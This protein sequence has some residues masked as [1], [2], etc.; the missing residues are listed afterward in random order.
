M[1]WVRCP[2]G[3]TE[4]LV[5]ARVSLDLGSPVFEQLVAARL[6]AR[7]EELW[8]GHRRQLREQRDALVAAM[9]ERLPDWRFRVPAGGLSL[10][11][12]LPAGPRDAGATALVA[13]AERLGVAVSPGPVF[14]V[15]GGLD[16]FVR[17]PY[18]RPEP[19]LRDGVDRLA[20]AWDV[21]RSGRPG[22]TPRRT[23]VMVA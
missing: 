14:A 13:E 1:G 3:V 19:E 23:R 20:E 12:E 10:W 15:D 18:A 5:A 4:R 6:L 22:R 9:A 11:C 8:E 21:V 7:R 2:A 17:I 16:R